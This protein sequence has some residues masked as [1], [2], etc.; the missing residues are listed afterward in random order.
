MDRMEALEQTETPATQAAIAYARLGWYVVPVRGKVPSGGS[1]WPNQATRDP[2]E[3][4]CLFEDTPHDGVGVVLG[5]KSDLIDLDCDSPDAEA[6]LQ[7]LF[8]GEVPAT[9][10]FRSAKGLHRLFRWSE[11]LPVSERTKAKFMLGALE[12]RIGGG[13]RAAQTVFPPSGG[14][15]W[16]LG[17]DVVAVAEL[18][19]TVLELIAL[20]MAETRRPAPLPIPVAAPIAE[21]SGDDRLNVRRWL[22]RHQVPILASDQGADG[23][24]RWFI[25]C[26]G[27]ETHTTKNGPR[28]CVITQEADGKLGGQCFH[29]S[30]GMSN[31]SQ[32]KAA[33]GPLEYA[34]YHDAP[35]PINEVAVAAILATANVITI[36]EEDDEEEATDLGDSNGAIAFP[37]E[38]LVAGGLLDD[39][40][41]YTLAESLYRQPELALGGALALLGTVTGRKVT[42]VFGTRTNVY[43][44]GLGLS[45]VGKEQARKINKHLL[46]RSGGEKLIGSERIGSHAGIVTTI[47]DT[48]ASLMQLDEMGRLLETM[49]DPR[50]S[51]HLFNCIT[52]MMQ[53]YSS[54]GTLWK[55]DAYADA[56]KVKTIDQPHLCIYGTATPDSFWHSLS[57]DNIAEG[58]IGRLLVLEGRGYEVE[59]QE[60]AGVP[61]PEPI[62]EA[63]RWWVDFKP[64]GNLGGEHPQPR[65]VPH[66]PEARERF[67]GHIRGINAKRKTETP[68]RAAVWSRSAEKVA[69]LA[70]LHACSRQYW[71]PDVITFE[72]IDWGVKLGNWLTRRLLAGCAEHVSENETEAKSKRVLAMIGGK[73]I[74]ARELSRKTQWI[75]GR[76][77]DEIVRDLI[78]CGLVELETITTARRPKTVLRR[79]Q[80]TP[81]ITSVI[82]S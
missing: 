38:C 9:P 23:A 24:R 67:L 26:P 51:P 1:G 62:I 27:I 55:A 11:S 66:S 64:G 17:P 80:R 35:D 18:P 77:R 25:R 21:T 58:L 44:L 7:E 31:W 34:D 40:V 76:E 45:G 57:T 71:V 60:P 46:L 70:L 39:I 74:T 56:K 65:I 50:K 33:I 28:D 69:K 72:D 12:V 19:A 43:V 13:D 63:L 2:G 47:H 6:T 73:G 82:T 68:L 32:L 79:K 22:D 5:P 61:P 78:A 41:A 15:E 10:T 14:R 16:M 36:D 3:A 81:P 4:A 49:K 29:A 75:R 53:L 48:P 54:S 59:M 52:V 37:A 20:R 30:C 42:D 8:G